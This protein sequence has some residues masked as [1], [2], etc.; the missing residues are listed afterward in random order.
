MRIR[1]AVLVVVMVTVLLGA[2]GSDSDGATGSEA[3]T[4]EPADVVDLS[5]AEFEDLTGEA[6]AEVDAVDNVFKPPYIIVK[7][8]TTVT[9]RN[10][11]RSNHNVYPVEE[12]VFE[13][14]ATDDFEPDTEATITFDEAGDYP[15]YCTLHATTT[16]GMVGAVRVVE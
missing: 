12:G 7:A 16:K 1:G 14:V 13:P 9:F 4:T 2:C 11:G 5:D 3:P 8:G 15:Y 6:T 10:A